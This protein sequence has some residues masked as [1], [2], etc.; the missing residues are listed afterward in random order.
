MLSSGTSPVQPP[1]AQRQRQ[2][3]LEKLQAESEERRIAKKRRRR[4]RVWAGLPADPPGPPRFPSETTIDE[5]KAFLHM[6]NEIYRQM[7]DQFQ[8]ICEEAGFIK[9]TVAGPDKWQA[10][11]DRLISESVHL[12]REFYGPVNEV[13][14][15]TKVLALDIVCTDV[16]KRMR[17]LERRMTIAEAKNTLGINPEESRQIRDEFYDILQADNFTSK[18]EAGNEH[19]DEL[20]RQWIAASTI[21]QRILPPA[22]EPPDPQQAERLKAIEVLCRDVMKRLRDDQAR[23]DPKRKKQV[24]TGPGPGPAPPRVAATVGSMTTY[25]PTAAMLSLDSPTTAHQMVH[26]NL[27]IDP[28]L[29][30][31]AADDDLSELQH[32]ATEGN[33][34]HYL[35]TDTHS[36]P[37][38]AF[39]RLSPSSPVQTPPKVWLSTLVTCSLSELRQCASGQH[40]HAVV[41]KVEGVMTDPATN[42]ET[43][44]V[45]DR[46]DELMAYLAYSDG[47]KPTFNVHLQPGYN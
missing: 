9:K 30:A 16:T 6:D 23:K 19:W 41:K 11:K 15:E 8:R 38:P 36:Q 3:R 34:Y 26:D 28:S 33:S 18:L 47:N 44:F 13:E 5:S 4:T 31:A 22:V 20:K 17:T 7:R 10:A 2:L 29:L 24:N 46:D 39:F 1:Q 12:N 32:Y 35:P 40:T 45:I 14:F 25:A 37:F 42:V 43:V 27:E 21:L